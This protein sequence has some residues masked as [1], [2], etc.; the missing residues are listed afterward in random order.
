MVEPLLVGRLLQMG[1][2][3]LLVPVWRF[4]GDGLT[5]KVE[6]DAWVASAGT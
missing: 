6:L 2:N 5:G 3:S 1:G 4:V